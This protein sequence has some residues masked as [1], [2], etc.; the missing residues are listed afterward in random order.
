MAAEANSRH[1]ELVCPECDHRQLEPSMVISTICR[2]CGKYMDISNG[3]PKVR[4]NHATRRLASS[5]KPP[6]QYSYTAPEEK[7]SPKEKDIERGF[8]K[9]LF[10]GE[11]AKISVDCYHCNRS[12]EVVQDAQSTQCPKCGGYI[13]L[14]NYEIDQAWHR[15]IQTRGNVTIL[16]GASIVGVKVTCHDLTVL[17][18]LSASVNC[19]GKL[20]IRNHGKIVGNVKCAELRVER[21]SQVEFQGD[22]S[23][24][25][26]YIDGQVKAQITCSG[27]ITLEKKSHLQGVARAA[28]LIVKSGAKHSGLME[29]IRPQA[30]ED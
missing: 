21:G 16:K 13:A 3:K 14:R 5:D 9:R 23:T 27:T 8:L 28:E 24:K 2:S 18:S 10:F 29:V 7:Q 6:L 25:T 1:I 17:G 26:V 4:P 12:F 30:V 11:S 19:S 20:V 15:R 22:V